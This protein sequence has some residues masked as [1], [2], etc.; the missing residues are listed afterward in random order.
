MNINMPAFKKRTGNSMLLLLL[1]AVFSCSAHSEEPEVSFDGLVLLQVD[2]FD[3]VY[4]QPDAA[5]ND[6]TSVILVKGEARFKKNWKR[7]YESKNR[8]R[9]RESDL[10]RIKTKVI[11]ELDDVFREELETNKTLALTEQP[12]PQTLIVRPSL[13]NLDVAAPDI[14]TTARTYNYTSNAGEATLVLEVFD[15]VSGDVLARVIDRQEARDHDYYKLTSSVTNRADARKLF[16]RWA[17]RLH[18]QLVKA[19]QNSGK[20]KQPSD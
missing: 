15:S 5:L 16:R 9:I 20:P 12:G 13:I 14:R 17:D 6:Y 7:N 19:Q 8:R 3:H 18:Q 1:L 10:T 4:V 11:D 2:D